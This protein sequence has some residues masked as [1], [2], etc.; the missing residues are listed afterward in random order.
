M[1]E[2]GVAG[3]LAGW[4]LG[5]IQWKTQPALSSQCENLDLGDR[6]VCEGKERYR[7]TFLATSE[8]ADSLIHL[9]EDIQLDKHHFVSDS[10]K[11]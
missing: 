5:E 1:T 4:K 10:I 9:L 7:I 8:S 3:I 2:T 11:K 6:S